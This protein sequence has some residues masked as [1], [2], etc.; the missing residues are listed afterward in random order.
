VVAIS[1]EMAAE[2]SKAVVIS[3]VE[4][5]QVE[6]LV[7]QNSNLV[8]VKNVQKEVAVVVLVNHLRLQIVEQTQMHVEKERLHQA[9][10]VFQ[11]NPQQLKIT[12][13]IE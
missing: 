9:D 13:N 2:A 6:V 5:A 7:N 10:V 1:K 3:N 11:I 8:V 12:R 4:K